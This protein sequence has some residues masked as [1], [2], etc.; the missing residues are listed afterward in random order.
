MTNK[1]NKVKLKINQIDITEDRITSRGGLS[2]FVRY[3]ENINMPEILSSLFS[4]ITKSKK[5]KSTT[6]K[7]KQVICNFF[8]GTSY[9][10]TRFDELKNDEGYAAGIE[11]TPENLLSSHAAKRFFKSFS[12]GMQLLFRKLFLHLFI[13]R[14]QITKPT[15]ITLG[16]DTMVMDNDDAKVRQGVSP[17]YKKKMGFQ[18]LQLYWENYIIDAI[19]RGGS[20]S[21]NHGTCV[22]NMVKRVVKFIRKKY[23]TCIPI[24]LRLD[25]GFFD[26]KNFKEFESLNIGYLCGGRIYDDIKNAIKKID[27]NK[28]NTLK[29]KKISW[30]YHV[31]EDKRGTWDKSRK[32][33]Y[34]STIAEDDQMLLDFDRTENIFYTNIGMD[35]TLTENLKKAGL[36]N[37]D[38]PKELISFYHRR[39]KDE[40]VNRAFKDFGTEKLPF[41]RFVPNAIF[42]YIMLLSYILFQAFKEDVGQ[43]SEIKD[44]YASTFRRKFLDFAAKIISKGN[45]IILKVTKAVHEQLD[46]YVLWERCN[47]ADTI[48]SP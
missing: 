43:T 22:S 16:I 4:K 2:L 6:E 31:F 38:Q 46:L 24:L 14:L 30:Q 23:S 11:T 39:A 25:G 8:D 28:L 29:K 48:L 41:K 17:T 21:G 10:M 19:F 26:Q 7:F 42:Y 27:K 37:I 47:S 33:I 40:L 18:P 32:A 35:D 15:V 20:K 12:F 44:M 1:A 3:F 13:W 9:K 45:R 5:G 34:T 36:T